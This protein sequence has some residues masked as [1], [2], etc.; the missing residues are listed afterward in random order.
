MND[1]NTWL[2]EAASV[3]DEVARAAAS[4]VLGTMAAPQAAIDADATA[5]GARMAAAAIR[6]RKDGEAPSC[7]LEVAGHGSGYVRIQASM[8]PLEAIA[9]AEDWERSADT[10]GGRARVI[11]ATGGIVW[12]GR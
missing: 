8:P 2:E 7:W 1:K 10:I 11:S 9:A 4:V 12:R 6:A 3:A 5:R